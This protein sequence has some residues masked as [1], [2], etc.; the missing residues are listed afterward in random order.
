MADVAGTSDAGR[1]AARPSRPSTSR[2][3]A[4]RPKPR[5]LK[6]PAQ[7]I[8]HPKYREMITS[9]ICTLNDRKGSSRQAILKYIVAHYNVG[10][11]TKKIN[12]WVKMA[13]RAGIKTG[14]FKQVRGTGA[15][16]SFRLGRKSSRGARKPR[17]TRKHKKVARKPALEEAKTS[18]KKVGAAGT[19]K[20]VAKSKKPKSAVAKKLKHKSP[21]KTA[22]Q[23][24]QEPQ[25]RTASK[26]RSK[27]RKR[28][29]SKTRPEP[30]RRTASKTRSE[31]RKRTESKTRTKPRKRTASKTRS[32]PQR[33]T[34]SKTRSEPQWRTASK[35]RTRRRKRLA[36]KTRSEPQ[37][38][39]KSQKTKAKSPSKKMAKLQKMAE[40]NSAK[41]HSQAGMSEET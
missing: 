15:S 27:P 23:T 24:R 10:S 12:S 33:R 6:K 17:R 13:L 1:L 22:S 26:T 34:A 36:Y 9:A 8:E 37:N 18:G 14:A 2:K 16:G 20:A 39:T 19:K 40:E 3:K 7:R 38:K 35:T 11:E 28:T 29:A 25:K 21:K 5:N 30:Q 31:P 41:K 4:S 32:E